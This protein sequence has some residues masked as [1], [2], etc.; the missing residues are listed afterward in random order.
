[1]QK[2][3]KRGSLMA[4]SL[5]A[6]PNVREAIGANGLVQGHAYSVTG[7]STIKINLGKNSYDVDLVRLR[8][9]WVSFKLF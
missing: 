6:D 9:P 5:K 2:A 4:C 7:A 3:I 1:M 8:N